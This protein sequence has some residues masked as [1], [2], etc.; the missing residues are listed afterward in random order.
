MECAKIK[1][2]LAALT[3]GLLDKQTAQKVRSHLAACPDC[4]QELQAIEK[5]WDMIGGLEGEEPEAGYVS[6]FWTRLA[7]HEPWYQTWAKALQPVFSVR[8]LVPVAAV[9]VVLIVAGLLHLYPQS[10]PEPIVTPKVAQVPGAR[11]NGQVSVE[12]VEN[13]DMLEE[14]ELLEDWEY[15]Q[16]LGNS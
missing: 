5:A 16:A 4:A 15:V 1:K 12:L 10:G 3:E 13:M 8:R 6:R 11:T 14:L 2:Q 7:Q 9:V